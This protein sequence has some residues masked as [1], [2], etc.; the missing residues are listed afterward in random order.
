MSH[1]SDDLN[2]TIQHLPLKRSFWLAAFTD[3]V[4]AFAI[5]V[6]ALYSPFVYFYFASPT[7]ASGRGQILLVPV[8]GPLVIAGTFPFHF[9][10]SS[11]DELLMILYAIGFY[12]GCYVVI[13][14]G[15]RRS[16]WWTAS[17]TAFL[18]GLAFFGYFEL[19]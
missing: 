15:Y 3:S 5:T 12:G 4:I 6:F 1:P 19:W 8:V 11:F 18:V 16:F 13:L 9:P 2:E 17:A 7:F 10:Q 14:L